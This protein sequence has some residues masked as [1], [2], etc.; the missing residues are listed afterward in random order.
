M[1]DD[2]TTQRIR[3]TEHDDQYQLD[4]QLRDPD[5][6]RLYRNNPDEFSNYLKG[7]IDEFLG[8]LHIPSE[9]RPLFRQIDIE[10]QQK[11][12]DLIDLL[13]DID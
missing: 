3:I 10:C 8:Y 6:V 12:I 1:A 11:K 13:E 5:I 4:L 7:K 9:L 2:E